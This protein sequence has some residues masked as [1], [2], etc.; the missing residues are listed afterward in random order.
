M[1]SIVGFV[2]LVFV[3]VVFVIY[4]GRADVYVGVVIVFVIAVL[5]YFYR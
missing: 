1:I 2:R 4:L 5:V 3:V